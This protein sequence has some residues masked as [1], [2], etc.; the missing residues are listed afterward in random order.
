MNE[1]TQFDA[2]SS[3]Q[4]AEDGQRAVAA[5]NA[6]AIA[7]IQRGFIQH[8]RAIAPEAGSMDSLRASGYELPE[9]THANAIGSA[10]AQLARAGVIE[11]VGVDRGKRPRAHR[12]KIYT[13]R[14]T[15]GGGS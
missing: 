15:D 1:H 14:L 11:C 3:Q 7:E 13:W 8:L 10:I 12:A 9:L 2:A 5:R 4:A 6:D